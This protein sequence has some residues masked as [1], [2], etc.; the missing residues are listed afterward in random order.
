MQG[1]DH[2]LDI[3]WSWKPTESESGRGGGIVCRCLCSQT[4]GDRDAWFHWG[5]G[6][7]F[8]PR[9]SAGWCHYGLRCRRAQ[10][11]FALYL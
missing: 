8:C 6:G 11:A 3:V 7:K 4:R 10:T 5:A 2:W 9:T 1:R